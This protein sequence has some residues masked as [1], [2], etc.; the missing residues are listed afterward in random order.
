MNITP[1]KITEPFAN[2][3]VIVGTNLAGVPGAGFAHFVNRDIEF[4]KGLTY[5]CRRRRFFFI[6]KLKRN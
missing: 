5:G 4:I 1:E 6:R 3:I 2:E